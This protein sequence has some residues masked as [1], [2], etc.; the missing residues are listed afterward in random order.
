[1]RS[2][3]DIG[4]PHLDREVSFAEPRG[5]VPAHAPA[6]HPMEWIV[7]LERVGAEKL[8]IAYKTLRH[9]NKP[10]LEVDSVREGTACARHNFEMQ[11]F[12]EGSPLFLQQVTSKDLILSVNGCCSPDGMKEQLFT[13]AV[14]RLHVKRVPEPEILR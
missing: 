12:G 11:Q 8:G 9:A 1:M 14:V 6:R 7:V 13:A 5:P 4:L 3:A 2:W 10:F